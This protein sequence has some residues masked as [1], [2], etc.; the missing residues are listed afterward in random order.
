HM[1]VGRGTA[2]PPL[3]RQCAG[4]A[5]RDGA[6]GHSGRR[7]SADWAGTPVFRRSPAKPGD[8]SQG[9]RGEDCGF[10]MTAAAATRS[11]SRNEHSTPEWMLG[12]AFASFTEAANTL[13]RS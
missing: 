6:G 7:I 1:R 3:G 10:L 8:H 12:R 4:V 2:E 11:T 5:A 13:E 9:K